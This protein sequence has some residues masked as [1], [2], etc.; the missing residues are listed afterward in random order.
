M[1]KKSEVCLYTGPGAELAKD[2]EFALNKLGVS[3]S[4]LNEDDIEK[5]NLENYLVLI[6]PG[7][8]TERTVSSLG[9]KGF[10]MIRKFVADGGGYIGI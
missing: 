5:G 2:V 3:Y 8:Y 1:V 10:K 6:I 7:G 4:K 9:K